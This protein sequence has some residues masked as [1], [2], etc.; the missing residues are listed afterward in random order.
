MQRS[1]AAE[2]LCPFDALLDRLDG[3]HSDDAIEEAA[4]RFRVSPMLVARTRLDDSGML[5]SHR[6]RFG[7]G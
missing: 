4:N 6:A 7:L 5:D 2:L 1:F 3:D